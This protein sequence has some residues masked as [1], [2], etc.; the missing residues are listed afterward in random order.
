MCYLIAPYKVDILVQDT[1]PGSADQEERVT[2]QKNR[3]AGLSAWCFAHAV[4]SSR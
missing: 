3:P 1:L 4:D 2:G